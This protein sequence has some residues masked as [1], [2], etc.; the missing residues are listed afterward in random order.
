MSNKNVISSNWGV[1]WTG[2]TDFGPL[3]TEVLD[4]PVT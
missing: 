1:D 3:E 2:I 4:F